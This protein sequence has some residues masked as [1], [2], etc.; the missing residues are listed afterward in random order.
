MQTTGNISAEFHS[1]QQ[2]M[3]EINAVVLHVASSCS[4]LASPSGRTSRDFPP[5]IDDCIEAGRRNQIAA[6]P[7]AVKT[8]DETYQE[9]QHKLCQPG[10][11]AQR[12]PPP[13]PQN[14][15]DAH[16]AVHNP[17]VQLPDTK[18]LTHD[19]SSPPERPTRVS[20]ML[21]IKSFHVDASDGREVLKVEGALQL[22]WTDPRVAVG[23]G[24]N[25]GVEGLVAVVGGSSGGTAALP[26][27]LWWDLA[28][29]TVFVEDS[30]GCVGQEFLPHALGCGARHV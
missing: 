29:T 26:A 6:A 18:I 10:Q 25:V 19:Y 20:A 8:R 14:S 5:S 4:G 9:Q 2:H 13:L 23:A 15:P 21:Q 3:A 28:M 24:G 27:D 17:H 16:Q 22:K 30:F 7:A 1:R 12:P 11:G